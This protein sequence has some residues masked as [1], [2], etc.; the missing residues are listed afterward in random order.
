[1][2]LNSIIH[3]LPFQFIG[4]KYFYIQAWK[5]VKHKS[6]NMDVLVVLAT[7][8]S[9]VYSFLVVVVAMILEE[10]F[11]PVTFFETT[12]M[13]MV[14]ISLGRWLEHIAKVYLY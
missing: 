2:A 9:Y 10:A 14:F 6:A 5:A 3:F 11:S 12:P 1:L 7:T 4:G 13:L 8:I